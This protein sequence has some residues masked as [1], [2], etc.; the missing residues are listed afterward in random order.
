M[1]AISNAIVGAS[2]GTST[3][4]STILYSV[5]DSLLPIGLILVA[6]GAIRAGIALSH[7]EDDIAGARHKKRLVNCI[8]GA[9]VI[10]VALVAVNVLAATASSWVG[11]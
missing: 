3:D 2:G 7:A 8:I 9:V 6:I 11:S 5:F 10:S 1:L 4:I